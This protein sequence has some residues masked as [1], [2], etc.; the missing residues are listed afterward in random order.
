MSEGTILSIHIVREPD[1][2]P[3]RVESIAVVTDHGL[4]GDHRSHTGKSRQL[5]LI[6]RAKLDD[7]AQVLC[8][9]VPEGASRRQIEISGLDLDPLIGKT[10][11]VGPAIVRV[12]GD[13]PPCD[14]METS[15]GPGARAAMQARAGL[16]CTVIKGG[17]I[18][19]R[20]RVTVAPTATT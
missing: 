4:D 17:E 8:H 5:T 7:V 20:Q 6:D 15:I 13:C 12:D 9:P 2:P 18:R 19:P 11:Y 3:E 14:L 16:C 1:G 10:L